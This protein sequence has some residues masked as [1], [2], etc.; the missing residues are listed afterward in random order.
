[1][2][3]SLVVAI[4]LAAWLLMLVA[5]AWILTRMN[6]QVRRL[7]ESPTPKESLSVLVDLQAADNISIEANKRRIFAVEGMY[8]DLVTRVKSIQA[9][10]NQA[11]RQDAKVD[12]KSL[13][14]YIQ[15]AEADPGPVPDEPPTFDVSKNEEIDYR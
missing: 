7:K 12:L 14:D 11:E 1:M 3:T 9:R 4:V 8:E 15:A 13:A 2:I 6:L 10:A 5:G